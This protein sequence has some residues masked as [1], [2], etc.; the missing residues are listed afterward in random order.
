[1]AAIGFK[2]VHGGADQRR[3]T[4]YA[5][6]L[7]AMEEMSQVAPAHNPPYI[8]AMRLLSEK[9][10]EIPLVAAFE[11]GF[12]HTVPDRNRYYAGAAMSGPKSNMITPL[13]LS[14]CQP[15]LH[16]HADR[17]TAGAATPANHLLPSGRVQFAVRDPRRPERGHSDGHEPPVGDCPQQPRGRFRSL[18]DAVI[19]KQPARRLSK[20]WMIWPNGAAC[21]D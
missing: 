1:M 4:R 9:L 17:R 3:G 19:M 2:A 14:R 5:E 16:C 10:P 20:C 8:A 6:I 18:R 11:T 7:S 12:H 21:W 15:S 13:G